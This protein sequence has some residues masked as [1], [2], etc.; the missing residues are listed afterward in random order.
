MEKARQKE[1]RKCLREEKKRERKA[2]QKLKGDPYNA[3]YSCNYIA[4]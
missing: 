3:I 2:G 4:S 1:M